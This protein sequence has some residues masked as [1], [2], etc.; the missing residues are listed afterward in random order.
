MKQ[1]KG[2]LVDACYLA[3]N[4]YWRSTRGARHV[5]AVVKTNGVIQVATHDAD[6]SVTTY[7]EVTVREKML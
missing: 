2:E 1:V 4:E 7:F 6:H 5:H 3:I